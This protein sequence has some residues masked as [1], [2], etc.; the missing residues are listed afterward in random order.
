MY[1]EMYGTLN[2]AIYSL[3]FWWALFLVLQRVT[4]RY[5]ESNSWKRDILVTFIQSALV[6]VLLPVLASFFRN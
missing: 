3:L 4:N 5:P 2:S 6:I 1:S